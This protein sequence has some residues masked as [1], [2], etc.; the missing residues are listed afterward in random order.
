MKPIHTLLSAALLSLTLG[1]C[2]TKITGI[3]DD[4]LVTTSYKAVDQLLNPI[5]ND[6][7]RSYDFLPDKPIIVASFVNIDNVQ[8]SSRLGRILAE[9]FGSRLA[10]KGYQVIELK[11]R[12]NSVFIQEKSGEFMLS[13]ELQD[14]SMEHDAQAVIVGTY[15]EGSDTVYV[16]TKAVRAQ[17]G[18]ILSA[19]DYQ[20]PLGPNT[21]SL[22]RARR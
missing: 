22:L 13:R 8:E 16:T 17:N 10:Q 7:L 12:T 9:Q 18:V 15:A 19:Y 1:A 11:L 20:L 6:P 3:Q 5:K 21:K 2:S 4:N 14:I